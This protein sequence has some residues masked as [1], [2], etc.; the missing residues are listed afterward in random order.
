MEYA[1]AA[2]ASASA[3]VGDPQHGH[4]PH[5]YGDYPYPYGAYYQPAPATDPSATAASSSYYYPVASAAPLSAAAAASYEPYSTYQYYGTPAAPGG[6]GVGG[7]GLVE[8]Y[9][10][11]DEASHQSTV[12]PATYHA[13][14]APIG[15]DTGKHLGFD[16]QRYAQVRTSVPP[17]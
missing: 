8:Y 9:F 1:T 3:P 14:T 2:E 10:T 6:A 17:L 5:P 16:P 13:A 11:A 12:A 4:Y 7:A 15:K